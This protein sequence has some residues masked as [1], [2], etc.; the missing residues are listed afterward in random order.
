VFD[1]SCA[2][3]QRSYANSGIKAAVEAIGDARATCPFMDERKYI[4]VKIENGKAVQQ[5]D[6]YRDALEA[7]C[8]INVPVAKHH[9]L[10]RLTLGMKN[11]MGICGGRRGQIHQQIAQKLAELTQV[12]R[13]KLTVIDA[14][15]IM[16]R[17]GPQSASPE[18]V[19]VIDTIVASADPVAADA[20]ATTLFD[21]K[22]GDIGSTV[23]AYEMG[24][25]EMNL[26]KIRV[27]QA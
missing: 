14:T 21:L 25:G 27:V 6:L 24:M 11:V 16:L 2:N 9:G 8:Y 3:A 19:K 15:R 4:P 1:R 18:D 12:V 22:P 13:P 26:D 10:T 20:Y 7:D 23:A 17:K 5:W